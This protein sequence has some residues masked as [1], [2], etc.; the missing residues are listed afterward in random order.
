MNS[1]SAGE[2]SRFADRLL[3]KLLA[4]AG[5][6]LLGLWFA[7]VPPY[8][9][10]VAGF[11]MTQ[12]HWVALTLVLMLAHMLAEDAWSKQ[13]S[14]PLVIWWCAVVGMNLLWYIGSGG[15]DSSVLNQR[16]LALI[17]FAMAYL[18]LASFPE[19]VMALRRLFAWLA[20]MGVAFSAYDMTHPFTFVPADH[21]FAH[22]GRA[23]GIYVNPNSAGAAFVLAMTLSVGTMAQKWRGLFISVCALGVLLSFSRA[24]M[25]AFVI[26]GLGLLWTR[27]ISWRTAR[28]ALIL[29]GSVI[30]TLTI[31][32]WPMVSELLSSDAMSRLLWFLD[33]TVGADFSQKERQFLAEQGWEQFVSSP[34]WGNGVG[35]TELWSLRASTH[36]QYIQ[37]LSD[38]GLLGLF[39]MPALA[40]ILVWR[41]GLKAGPHSVVA[42]SILFFCI[43]SHNMLTEYYWLVAFAVAAVI[44][45]K[46]S[47]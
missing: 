31:F 7:N 12:V 33:P 6:I 38:F 46:P 42:A 10:L 20:V 26:A 14:G 34:L 25:V 45:R 16:L 23:S 29:L 36:N 2:I 39:I 8:L 5:V 9:S 13:V 22:I 37:F 17:F 15:G 32:L 35:S 18:Y 44:G 3:V 43:A 27:E 11:A 1:V 19:V 24:A 21:E 41:P 47:P 28:S 30:A 40:V 4:L